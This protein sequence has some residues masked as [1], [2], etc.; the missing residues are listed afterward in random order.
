MKSESPNK[1]LLIG[2][3]LFLFTT[4]IGVAGY[5]TAGLSF[6][7]SIYMVIITIFGVG[8]G[9]VVE[10]TNSVRVFT[11]V[12]IVLGCTSLIYTVGAFI[13]WLTE[14]QLKQLLGRQHMEKEISQLKKHTAICGYGRV[15]RLLST[16]LSEAGKPFIII[17]SKAAED[18]SIRESGYLHIDGDATEESVLRKAGNGHSQ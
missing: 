18:E 6:L 9:E 8:Y 1:H 10:M 4:I 2:L 15:G 7:D 3:F 12:F 14:G 5:R 11:M 13:N 17:D 16:R